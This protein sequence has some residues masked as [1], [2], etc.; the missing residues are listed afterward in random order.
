MKT[1]TICSV[2]RTNYR[3]TD[4]K[5]GIYLRFTLNR[6]IYFISLG[7]SVAEKYWNARKQRVND[8]APGS[9]DINTMLEVYQ[10][11]ARGILLEYRLKRH[12]LTFERFKGHFL[13]DHYGSQ[14][15]LNYV[16]DQIKASEGVLGA[17]TLKGYGD[18]L[19]KL[20]DFRSSLTFSE[21]DQG[22]IKAYEKF[23]ATSRERANNRNTIN[24][25]LSFLRTMLNRAKKEGHIETHIFEQGAKVGRIEGD[26]EFLTLEELGVLEKVYQENTL[27]KSMQEVLQYFLFACYTGIRD[28]DLRKLCHKDVENGKWI[29]IKTE[30]TGE[31]VRIPLI[32]KAKVLISE[33][34]FDNQTVFHVKVNQVS[35]RHLKTI[36]D[37]VGIKKNISMHCARHTFAT[38]SLDLG[39]PME[40]VQAMLG[41]TDSKTTAIYAKIRDGLKEKEM[42]KWGRDIGFI[43]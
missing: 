11:K 3:H 2:L 30:K 43:Q 19:N 6:K 32:E 33:K 41:H 21:I 4:G 42:G 24:K 29:A 35:N 10:E 27:K 38:V 40:V 37:L 22:F 28:G 15:F 9:F 5:Y 39:V 7:L 36:M 14:S 1:P 25:S 13:D 17:G 8:A 18:Q 23:L 31:P 34:S 12:V 26:K 20:K 16:A